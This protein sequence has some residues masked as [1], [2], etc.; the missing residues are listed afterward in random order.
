MFVTVLTVFFFMSDSV[1]RLT[2]FACLFVFEFFVCYD[3]FDYFY[4]FVFWTVFVCSTVF[5]CLAVFMCLVCILKI[6][7]K[8]ICVHFNIGSLL[9]N[10]K[11]I[12]IQY[13]LHRIV[14]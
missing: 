4:E 11:L 9:F 6:N 10:T 7:W 2:V 3:E 14:C 13:L 12:L 8:S 1:F 5:A